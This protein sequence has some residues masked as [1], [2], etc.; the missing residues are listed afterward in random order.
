MDFTF[1]FLYNL[2]NNKQKNNM[3]K[4]ISKLKTA[5]AIHGKLENDDLTKQPQDSEKPKKTY[6]TLDQIFGDKGLSKYNTLDVNEYESYLKELNLTDLQA[7]A[8]RVGIFPN[9]DMRRLVKN[10]LKEFQLYAAQY[11]TPATEVKQPVKL[12]SRA[13]KILSEGK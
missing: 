1:S 12:T 3:P 10:L 11:N 7:H 8:S 2:L 13:Q 9:D 6:R 4:K 5:H